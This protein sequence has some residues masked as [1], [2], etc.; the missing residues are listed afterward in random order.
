MFV[1]PVVSLVSYF[2]LFGFSFLC[3][4]ILPSQIPGVGSSLDVGRF[5]LV[6]LGVSDN[7]LSLKCLTKLGVIVS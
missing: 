3:C 2:F 1:A 4:Y 5:C 6:S 7:Y